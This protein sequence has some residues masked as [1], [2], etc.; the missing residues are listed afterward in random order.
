MKIRHLIA[1]T[2]LAVAITPVTFAATQKADR[3]SR[4]EARFDKQSAN[5]TAANLQKAKDL[6]DEGA[7]LCSS[8]KKAEGAKKLQEA[9]KMVGGG[10][11][12]KTTK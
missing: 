4:L 1:A 10:T 5:S 9:L 8:G 3:C 7:K 6:R 12:A 2:A 11:A